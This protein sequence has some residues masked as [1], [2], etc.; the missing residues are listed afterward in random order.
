MKWLLVVGVVVGFALVSPS[1]ASAEPKEWKGAC[2]CQRADNAKLFHV[3]IELS[4]ANREA[5]GKRMAAGEA[6]TMDK[7]ILVGGE[8]KPAT[9]CGKNKAVSGSKTVTVS[10]R[11]LDHDLPFDDSV[12]PRAK[13]LTIGGTE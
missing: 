13:V 6:D 9:L 4:D 8:C 3:V 11:R 1:P 2:L 12:F 7:A 10:Y 5:I